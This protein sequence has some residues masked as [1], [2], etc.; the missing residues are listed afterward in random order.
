VGVSV[1]VV[2]GRAVEVA[3]GVAVHDDAV[4]VA[5]CSAEGPQPET[6]MQIKMKTV[7]TRCFLYIFP[8]VKN[9]S[10]LIKKHPIKINKQ[11]LQIIKYGLLKSIEAQ[12]EKSNDPTQLRPMSYT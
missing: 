9:F 2:V 4:M 10:T 8:P 6:I 12:L 1:G 5:A 11:C 3:G 7:K